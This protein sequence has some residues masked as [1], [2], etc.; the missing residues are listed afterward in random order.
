MDPRGVWRFFLIKSHRV[1]FFSI[2]TILKFVITSPLSR[3]GVFYIKYGVVIQ[4]LP[5]RQ[6]EVCWITLL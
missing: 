2:I 6:G 4:G 1:R 5:L 3:H